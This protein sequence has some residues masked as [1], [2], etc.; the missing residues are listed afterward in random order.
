M[1]SPFVNSTCSHC[2]KTNN[3]MTTTHAQEF[4]RGLL[5]LSNKNEA[6]WLG[7]RKDP[8]VEGPDKGWAWLDGSEPDPMD[9]NI[10]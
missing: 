7:M 6:H 5:A 4:V 2:H 1:S 9:P 10:K 3:Y 8:E